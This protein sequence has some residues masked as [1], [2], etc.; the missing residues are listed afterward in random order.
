MQKFKAKS[1][2][3][4]LMM[5]FCFVLAFSFKANLSA[6]A[7]SSGTPFVIEKNDIES[8][9]LG[10]NQSLQV[11]PG[12]QRKLFVDIFPTIAKDTAVSIAYQIT[13]GEGATISGDTLVISE[14]ATIGETI[15]VVAI[16]DDVV[17]ENSLVFTVVPILVDEVKILNTEEQIKQ[18]E[19]L[20]LQ[21][22][23][24]P[25]NATDKNLQYEIVSGKEHAQI[26]ISGQ[27]TVSSDLESGDLEIIVRVSSIAQSDV[28]KEKTFKLYKPINAI[29]PPNASL[30][31]VEQKCSYSFTAN[32]EPFNAT[33]GDAPV[34]YS[35]NV[36]KDIATIDQNGKLTI[37][38]T[39][40][41]GTKIV[42]RIDAT[43]GVFYEQEVTVVPVYAT[44]FS[45]SI[46]SRPTHNGKYLPGDT[47]VISGEFLEP[48]NITEANK[49]F[50]VLVDNENLAYVENNV[51]KIR[52]INE[53]S[54]YLPKLKIIV[55]TNQNGTIL[56]QE[57]EVEIYVPVFSVSLPKNTN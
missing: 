17:S 51:V 44:S 22:K 3:M 12:E 32:V 46:K 48:F 29:V 30:K 21:T 20:L 52:T 37:S 41:I 5:C 7:E 4:L 42:V 16:V 14:N 2:L 50:E 57:F 15:E 40:P 33:F 6:S 54:G 36:S 26:S 19:T 43:D 47:I 8:V 24:L 25:E 55:Q 27:I 13:I 31:E 39:A 45:A 11:M 38:A 28:Y 10:T 18:G 56:K 35:V 34:S 53:V 23:V 9:S 1:F 49:V